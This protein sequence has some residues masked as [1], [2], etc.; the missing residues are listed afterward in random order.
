MAP[1]RIVLRPLAL[2]APMAFCGLA[3]ASTLVAVL[4]LG[5]IPAG[6]GHQVALGVL[7]IVVPLQGLAAIFVVLERDTPTALAAAVLAATWGAEAAVN[8][9]LA[10]G[11]TSPALG[12]LVLAAAPA[13]LVPAV[14]GVSSRV[15]PSVVVGAAAARFVLTGIHQL[16][17]G[18]AVRDASGV[19]GLGVATLA[20]YTALALTLEETRGHSVVPIGRRG[21]GRS[22]IGGGL[23]DQ[24]AGIEHAPGVRRPA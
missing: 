2:T 10:P 6:Q 7:V 8:L 5:G 12:T 3:I 24:L 13:L 21:A 15:L 4:Q 20:L 16:G 1:A 19:L 17:G 23:D 18:I 9:S 22:A 11:A 14:A